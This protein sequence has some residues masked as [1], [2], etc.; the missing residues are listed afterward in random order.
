MNACLT[1]VAPSPE[2]DARR[3][4]DYLCHPSPAHGAMGACFQELVS[5]VESLP[6]TTDE[7]CFA[8]NW[9]ASSRCL[10]Q[11]GELHAARYQVRM[12]RKTLGL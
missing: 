7:F 10:W 5:L 3:L 1:N 2:I 9:L 11:R 4:L 12:V 6:L 8:I